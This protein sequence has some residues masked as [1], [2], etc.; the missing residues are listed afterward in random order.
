[1]VVFARSLGYF[2]YECKIACTMQHR[3]SFV[4]EPSA[5]I[6]KR[7]WHHATSPIIRCKVFGIRHQSSI[8]KRPCTSLARCETRRALFSC[9]DQVVVY[10][11]S[12]VGHQKVLLSSAVGKWKIVSLVVKNPPVSCINRVNRLFSAQR[13]EEFGASAVVVVSLSLKK[14]HTTASKCTREMQ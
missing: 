14:S 12:T 3:L 9:N 4:A 5:S 8:N 2:M 1:M 7:P 11:V 6:N 10:E 13:T